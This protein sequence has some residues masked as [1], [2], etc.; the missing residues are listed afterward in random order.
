MKKNQPFPKVHPLTLT[1][2]PH[3]PLPSFSKLARLCVFFLQNKKKT[4]PKKKK[5]EFLS[6]QKKNCNEKKQ[7]KKIG[8]STK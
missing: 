3:F 2:N 8:K 5:N 4:F 6:L 7:E 1:H